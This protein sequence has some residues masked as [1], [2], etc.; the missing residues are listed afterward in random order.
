MNIFRILRGQIRRVVLFISISLS[1]VCQVWAQTDLPKVM[2]PSPEAS[3]LGKFVDMPVTLYNGLPQIN[4]PIFSIPVN[5]RSVP[6]SLSYHASGIKVNEIPSSVG[7]GWALNAG[8][9]ITRTVR[10]AVDEIDGFMYSPAIPQDSNCLTGSSMQEYLNKTD[11]I[12]GH[13]DTEPDLFYY[14]FNGISGKFVIDKNMAIHQIPYTNVKIIPSNSALNSWKII[15]EDGT[16]YT[17]DAKETSSTQP[18]TSIASS[19]WYLTS[20][21]YVDCDQEISFEY[22]SNHM[23]YDLPLGETLWEYAPG[24]QMVGCEEGIYIDV[25]QQNGQ[26]TIVEGKQIS[27]IT[28]PNGMVEFIQGNYRKDYTGG[29]FLQQIKV[30]NTGGLIK[31]FKLNYNYFRDQGAFLEDDGLATATTPANTTLRLSLKSVQEF[32]ADNITTLPPYIFQYFTGA[33][34]PDR[35]TSKAQDHWGYYNG[36]ANLTLLPT[37]Q[38]LNGSTFSGASRNPDAF[39]AKAGALT[40]IIYPTGG[41]TAFDYELNQAASG[42][43]PDGS[44]TP[45]SSYCTVGNCQVAGITQLV[46]DDDY[47]SSVPVTLQ[48]RTYQ[49]GDTYTITRKVCGS[50]TDGPLPTSSSTYIYFEIINVTD[51]G[52]PTIAYNSYNDGWGIGNLSAAVGRTIQ[53]ANGTYQIKAIRGNSNLTVSAPAITSADANFTSRFIFEVN[54]TVKRIPTDS[55]MSI[56]IGGLRIKQITAFDPVSQKSLIK[57]YDYTQNGKSSGIANWTPVYVH[58]YQKYVDDCANNADSFHSYNIYTASSSV[59]LAQMLGNIVGYGKVTVTEVDSQGQYGK[60]GKTE[61]FYTNPRDYVFN[62]ITINTYNSSSNLCFSNRAITGIN[63][64]P[65]GPVLSPDWSKGL[66]TDQIEYKS[67]VDGSYSRMKKVTNKYKDDYLGP[68]LEFN[69]Q[70]DVAAMTIGSETDQEMSEQSVGLHNLNIFKVQFYYIPSR[71]SKLT[72]AEE[73][74]YTSTDSTKLTKKYEYA[75][76]VNLQPTSVLIIDSRNDSLKTTYKYPNDFLPTLVY[77]TMTSK[78]RISPVVQQDISRN[79]AFLNQI[80][81]TY[82]T[83]PSGIIAP[84]VTETT[85]TGY[86]ADTRIQFFSYNSNGGILDVARKDGPHISYKWGY[87]NQYPL[88]EAKNASNS[89]FFT[90][91]FEENQA[92]GVTTGGAHTGKKLFV[93]ANYTVNWTRPNSRTYLLSYWCR[94]N[95]SWKYKQQPYSSNSITITGGDAYDDIRV[96][97]FDAQLTTYTFE[98]M[99]GMTSKMEP[100]GATSYYEFDGFQRLK[101]IRDQNGNIIKSINYHYKQ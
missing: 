50:N 30:S 28:F 67:N 48:L 89:E 41:S 61:Y 55:I 86:G 46:I 39:Y 23:V 81:T 85:K 25:V 42:S 40:K 22:T 96:F 99:V 37:H 76:I 29:R 7:L 53:L 64:F 101:N 27:K 14:N 71:F 38:R 100:D 57:S 58:P 68:L 26:Y 11:N 74:L 84:E 47:Q 35:L 2:P 52:N 5:G 21:K 66:L 44:G 24:L 69:P 8:G 79:G 17:F 49:P 92:A 73:T 16:E 72:E 63:K 97:P 6:I 32:A 54:A 65:F 87:N 90:E 70:Y 91:N 60:N 12:V 18:S 83:W 56:P 36:A 95:G 13:G 93:G 9:V 20:I 62:P 80:K 43:Y 33:V 77:S 10:G 75:S 88:T 15:T 78:N 34:L 31:S 98:P 45:L 82:N 4:I 51:P 94:V 19:S 3:S 1:F 59:P